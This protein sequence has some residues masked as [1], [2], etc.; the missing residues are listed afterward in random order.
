MIKRLPKPLIIIFCVTALFSGLIYLVCCEIRPETIF[1]IATAVT[2]F[3]YTLETNILRNL[4]EETLKQVACQTQL[5]RRAQNLTTLSKLI[6][7]Y[8]TLRNTRE[9]ILK[10]D[11]IKLSKFTSLCS[12]L[13]QIGMF[14]YHLPST[15]QILLIDQ[16]IETFVKCWTKLKISVDKKRKYNIGRDYAYFEWLANKSFEHYKEVFYPRFKIRSYKC[17]DIEFDPLKA[18]FPISITEEDLIKKHEKD[19]I[20]SKEVQ[21]RYLLFA[22]ENLSESSRT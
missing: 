11:R 14:I 16:W 7:D 21:R 9:K 22:K 19:F 6:S 15:E 10:G 8:N 3:W 4:T 1:L 17:E 18:D 5:S 2:V 12:S 13:D 20:G